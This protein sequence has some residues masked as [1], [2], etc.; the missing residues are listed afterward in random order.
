MNSL[1]LTS[2]ANSPTLLR[3]VSQLAALCALFFSCAAV[4]THAQEPAPVERLREL[5]TQA[6]QAQER[7]HSLSG[8]QEPLA[9]GAAPVLKQRFDALRDLIEQSPS[10]A[11]LVAFS[12]DV[13]NSLARS[14]PQAA[15]NLET[16]G[17]WQAPAE[18]LII[19]GVKFASSASV[20]R[21]KI[22][23]Q[24]V[25]LHFAQSNPPQF[26]SGDV[27]SVRGVR[28]GDRIAV[29]QVRVIAPLAAACTVTGEQNIVV[30][31]AN[32][33]SYGLASGITPNFVKGIMLGNSGG[34][35]QSTP[36][37]SVDDFWQQNSDGQ[38]WV[39]RTG[40]GALKVVGPYNP[41]RR[42]Q[43]GRSLRLQ[44]NRCGSL[45]RS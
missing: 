30:I 27:L 42:L 41:A 43:H 36:D 34:G 3:R 29:E 39:N 11:L 7:F 25:F 24:I 31:L 40:A 14:F 26:K 4:A 23:K 19:D 6:L 20:V 38:A 12:P 44:R 8:G 22:N 32:L 15:R 1:T 5:N 21:M 9:A 10:D 2:K 16:H 28:A 17:S 35:A 37:Y 18:Y 13:L 45:R 33:R